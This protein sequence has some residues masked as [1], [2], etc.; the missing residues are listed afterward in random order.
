[1]LYR[2]TLFHLPIF[3]ASQDMTTITNTS[4]CTTGCK[5][6][7]SVVCLGCPNSFYCITHH[8]EHRQQLN[9][10]LQNLID[11]C[12]QFREEIELEGNNPQVHALL[13]NIDQWEKKSIAQI[14]KVAQETTEQLLLRIK[15]SMPQVKDHLETLRRELNQDPDEGE[16]VDTHIKNWTNELERLKLLLNNSPFCRIQEHPTGFINKIYLE[17]SG[18]SCPFECNICFYLNPLLYYIVIKNLILYYIQLL[19]KSSSLT[20]LQKI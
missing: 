6:T 16:F 11:E 7:A 15:D 13:K 9:L 14:R 12:N 2:F 4:C 19:V 10:G 8:K 1:M 18:E 17:V 3:R 5:K 20:V